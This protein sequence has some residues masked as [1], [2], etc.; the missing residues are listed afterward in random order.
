MLIEDEALGLNRIPISDIS[1]ANEDELSLTESDLEDSEID[2]AEESPTPD[3]VVTDLARGLEDFKLNS[4]VTN[5]VEVGISEETRGSKRSKSRS[6]IPEDER[7]DEEVSAYGM[8]KKGRKKKG[9]KNRAGALTSGSTTPRVEAD[10]EEEG[11]EIELTVSIEEESERPTG[12][13]SRRAKKST[14]GTSSGVATPRIVDGEES[15]AARNGEQDLNEDD[16]S[17]EMSKKD[18][19]RAKEMAKFVDELASQ[20]PAMY[21]C[22]SATTLLIVFKLLNRNATSAPSRINLA[23]S[24]SITSRKLDTPS[25][26]SRRRCQAQEERRRINVDHFGLRLS[27]WN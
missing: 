16:G 9:K 10:A 11:E 21:E 8:A 7:S 26:P 20:F 27:D 23:P 17:K 3:K 14:P 24:Y 19:R 5:H 18:K 12:K 2:D 1:P 25:L 13:K 6:F 4:A 22:V 15:L